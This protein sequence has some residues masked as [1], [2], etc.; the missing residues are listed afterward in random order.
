MGAFGKAER[1]GCLARHERVF[2]AEA[3]QPLGVE[4]LLQL[5]GAE[6]APDGEARRQ[7]MACFLSAEDGWRD[8]ARDLGGAFA[9]DGARLKRT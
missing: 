9:E 6:G 2:Q 5:L 1:E 8:A 4:E 3:G 7:A